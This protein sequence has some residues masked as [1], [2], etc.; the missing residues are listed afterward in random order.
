MGSRTCSVYKYK[1]NSH[2]LC[3]CPQNK[4]S[5]HGTAIIPAQTYGPCYESSI[6]CLAERNVLLAPSHT[7]LGKEK[8]KKKKESYKHHIPTQHCKNRTNE[9]STGGR[10]E[11][12]FWHKDARLTGRKGCREEKV[13]HVPPVIT[14]NARL[15]A[16]PWWAAAVGKLGRQDVAPK[17][18]ILS[19]TWWP[20]HGKPAC[21]QRGS[22]RC[23]WTPMSV[24][25]MG[26]TNRRGCP[27][28][29][30]EFTLCS[31]HARW[32]YRRRHV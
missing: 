16:S 24:P 11:P 1:T 29:L 17:R 8:K 28:V 20:P 18:S 13:K 21:E 14:E 4:Q 5:L 30:V 2:F 26:K 19:R 7:P 15:Q 6:L 9:R 31:S 22:A 12:T 27:L 23:S 10:H 25:G 3:L 32:S